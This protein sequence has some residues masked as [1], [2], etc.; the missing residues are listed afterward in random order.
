[1]T[2]PVPPDDQQQPDELSPTQETVRDAA[3]VA[4]IALLLALLI[5]GGTTAVTAGVVW[6]GIVSRLVAARV[7]RPVA[8]AVTDLSTGRPPVGS[9]PLSP[10]AQRAA[11]DAYTRRAAYLLNAARRVTRDV[12]SGT[13]LPEAVTAEQRFWRQHLDAQ[14]AREQ[15]AQT[16]D[17]A[18]SA[19]G[20]TLA[21][22]SR[23]D[24]R[25]TTVC[26]IADGHTFD[27]ATGC[28]LGWPGFGGPHPQCRCVP[29]PARRG[30]TSVDAALTAAGLLRNGRLTP[31][32]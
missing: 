28:A 17:A 27:A 19:Y 14:T 29:G 24:D 20:P 32:H 30:A 13:P 6:T 2:Q 5:A 12:A 22:V 16:V 3:I 1:M 26:R 15:A 18:A 4:A 25:V 11:R 10:V 9:V 21:W 7:P 31:D 8:V 23:G